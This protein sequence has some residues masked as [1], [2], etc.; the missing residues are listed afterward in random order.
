MTLGISEMSRHGCSVSPPCPRHHTLL[1][2]AIVLLLFLPKLCVTRVLPFLLWTSW[3]PF[4]EVKKCR[5]ASPVWPPAAPGARPCQLSLHT[6]FLRP[7]NVNVYLNASCCW[8]I[9]SAFVCLKKVFVFVFESC[10]C[11][12]QNSSLSIFPFSTLRILFHCP[13]CGLVP[14][15]NWLLFWSSS[16]V[17][18]VS[19]SP[20]SKFVFL[21]RV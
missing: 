7:E 4:S 16:S 10:F 2:P 9:I 20:D 14:E 19:F 8:S 6:I 21:A 1:S 18:T 11:C 17:Y 13:L 15:Q 5:N 12:K 3:L